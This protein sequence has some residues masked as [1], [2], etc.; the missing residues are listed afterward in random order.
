MGGAPLRFLY[1][2]SVF[3]YAVGAEHEYR[4]PCRRIVR[5]AA[6]G[7]LFGEASVELIQELTHVLLRR[8]AERP[9]ALARAGEVA[10]L[11]RLHAFET[12][13]LPLMLTLLERHE[14]LGPRDALFAATALNRHI[15]AILSSDRHFDGITG[16]RRV[17][18]LDADAVA[19]L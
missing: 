6:D 8:R 2:T 17:D 10:Q 11:C 4:E 7:E 13:D 3:L 5:R 12:S 9:A 16:L 15:P 1:D 14:H 19:A 18:P